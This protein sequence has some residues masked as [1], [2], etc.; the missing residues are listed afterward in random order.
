MFFGEIFFDT[1]MKKTELDIEVEGILTINRESKVS[2]GNNAR[3]DRT[4]GHLDNI[5][6]RELRESKFSLMSDHRLAEDATREKI[7]RI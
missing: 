6:V 3:M 5:F 2:R 4:D 7:I 1:T